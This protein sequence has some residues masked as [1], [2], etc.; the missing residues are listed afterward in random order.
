MFLY[1]TNYPFRGISPASLAVM[2]L[3]QV[4]WHAK[5]PDIA[6]LSHKDAAL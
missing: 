6:K 4:V 5:S 3:S 1:Q 2:Q